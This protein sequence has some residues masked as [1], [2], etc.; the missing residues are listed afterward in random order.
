MFASGTKK[1]KK[2]QKFAGAGAELASEPVDI[3]VDSII[4]FLEQSTAYLRVV[5]NQVFALLS[6]AVQES[7]VDLILSVSPCNY[8]L[9][10]Q[11]YNFHFVSD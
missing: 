1:S 4:G 2:S 5:A 9:I 10:Q 8:S 6:G 11:I 3:L 7:T